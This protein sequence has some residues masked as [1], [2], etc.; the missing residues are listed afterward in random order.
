MGGDQY[1][2]PCESVESPILEIGNINSHYKFSVGARAF[3]ESWNA[4]GPAH[5]CAVGV[6]H[7][8]PKLAKFIGLEMVQVC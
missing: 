1:P 6:G 3:V 4:Q 2:L 7:L 8:A 5:H